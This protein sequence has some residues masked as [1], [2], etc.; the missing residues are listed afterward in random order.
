M[1]NRPLSPHCQQFHQNPQVNPLTGK[2]IDI[3]GPTY[4]KLV[5]E[6]GPP[7]AQP[8]AIPQP[9]PFPR[10][11]PQPLPQPQVIPQVI[12]QPQPLTR[13]T[14]QPQPRVMLQ[15]PPRV[16]FQHPP[17]VIPRPLPQPRVTPQP[18]PQVVTPTAEGE[19]QIPAGRGQYQ[20]IPTPP[21]EDFKIVATPNNLQLIQ[22]SIETGRLYFPSFELL[23][24]VAEFIPDAQE[25]LDRSQWPLYLKDASTYELY[26]I[27][28]GPIAERASALMRMVMSRNETVDYE[29][30]EEMDTFMLSHGYVETYLLYVK[31]DVFSH[32]L[33]PANFQASL[34][35][36]QRIMM[37]A[38]RINVLNGFV[39]QG[40]T[41]KAI[42][43]KDKLRTGDISASPDNI[44]DHLVISDIGY[45]K[46][47]LSDAIM[48]ALGTTGHMPSV[49]YDLLRYQGEEISDKIHRSNRGNHICPNNSKQYY[50]MI[51]N[52]L[53]I[54]GIIK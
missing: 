8:Q 3:G 19:L 25:Y 38:W 6:C 21:L 31:R 36:D 14:P 54:R 1:L 28:K 12:P 5:S 48:Q 22:S 2:R 37:E 44:P 53:I 17:R 33:N 39:N 26:R 47:E 29:V 49:P 18:Q 16:I 11:I 40:T 34:T 51:Y 15:P 52:E 42:L 4:R 50:M 24:Q 32:P 20:N 45:S 46:T 7:P 13:I 35:Q 30:I 9:Q 10:V 27:F 23:L 43:A 41:N